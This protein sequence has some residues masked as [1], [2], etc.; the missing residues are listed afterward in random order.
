MK[1]GQIP[2]EWL[3]GQVARGRRDGLDILVRRYAGPLLT[4]LTRMTGDRHRSEELFQDVFLAVWVKGRQYDP[5]RM[6]KPWL[7][8]IAINKC[9]ASFRHRPLPV[10]LAYTDDDPPQARTLAA[11][12][13]DSI[14]DGSIQRVSTMSDTFGDDPGFGHETPSRCGERRRTRNATA[15][16][17][18]T[19][20]QRA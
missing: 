15:C 5:F 2:D 11:S 7:Y 13:P 18:S 1:A 17:C 19:N 14:I 6:F 10:R 16:S 20:A 8:R 3:M 12:L 9:R 4:F